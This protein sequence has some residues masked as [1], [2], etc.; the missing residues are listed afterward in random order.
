MFEVSFFAI[1]LG[2][3]GASRLQRDILRCFPSEGRAVT[4]AACAQNLTQLA[5]TQLMR[6][7]TKSAQGLLK[8]V[9]EAVSS[10]EVGRRPTFDSEWTN[11][12]L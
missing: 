5:S 10:L 3:A 8:A 11:A 7:V 4:L 2:E 12:A 1:M 9:R 6:F